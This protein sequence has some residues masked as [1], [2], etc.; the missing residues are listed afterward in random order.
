MYKEFIIDIFKPAVTYKSK[1]DYNFID[2][3]FQNK[4][5]YISRG[6][7]GLYHI[8]K[9]L[10]VKNKILLPA[11]I[12]NSILIPLNKLNISPI[13]YDVDPIDLNADI[14][15]IM[16]LSSKFN[17]KTVLVASLYGNPA[18]LLEI[19]S[20]CRQHNI[21]MIDDA[22]QSFGAKLDGRYVGAFG[23]A[24]FFSFSPGKPL[25]G[26]M[27]G[28]FWTEKYDYCFKRRKH[29]I[30]HYLNYLDFYFNRLR[31]YEYK[32]FRVFRL[33][34]LLSR[35][36]EVIVDVKDDDIIVFG[37]EML[38]GILKALFDGEFE[39]RAKY[40]RMFIDRFADSKLFRVIR[41]IRGEASNHKFVVV[42]NSLHTASNLMKYLSRNKIY[43]LNGYPLLT[44]DFE[45]LPNSQ[46]LNNKVV[47]IP[48]EDD[49]EKMNYLFNVIER[50]HE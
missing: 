44:K 6:R 35:L 30:V 50:F 16:F 45:F 18:N 12:C 2:S 5:N 25:A 33:L 29:H 27:G 13:Y 3:I 32:K 15:S 49:E 23:N 47:E 46:E 14:N 39:F 24:G 37:E 22:A 42:E 21:L 34:T 7:W 1:L 38:G 9:S 10:D 4:L 41:N 36:M 31:I 20:Y 8:L 11:Y 19:E 17:V 26:Y 28:F 48:I 43:S 40:T